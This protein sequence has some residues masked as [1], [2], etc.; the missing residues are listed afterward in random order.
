[1]ATFEHLEGDPVA[2]DG[3]VGDLE[4]SVTAIDEAIELLYSTESSL[5]GDAASELYARSLDAGIALDAARDRYAGTASALRTYVVEMRAAHEAA[6][7]VLDA[8]AA[9]VTEQRDA[10]DAAWY[11]SN[12]LT[13]AINEAAPAGRIEALREEDYEARRRVARAEESLTDLSATWQAAKDRQDR[14]AEAAANAI[15]DAMDATND[16]FWDGVGDFFSSIGEGL[17]AAWNWTVE[18]LKGIGEFLLQFAGLALAF[19]VI[20]GLLLLLPGVGVGLALV[21]GG[22][23]FVGIAGFLVSASLKADGRGD[24]ELI[25]S[26]TQTRSADPEATGD[27]APVTGY[28]DLIGTE[29]GEVDRLTGQWAEYREDG[30]VVW[31]DREELAAAV[32]VV[33]LR[34]EDTGE[35]IG[36]R[37]QLPST[38]DWGT[39]S[40]AINDLGA[41]VLHALV[42]GANTQIERAAFDAMR[43]AGVFDS[44]APIMLTGWSQGGMTAGE[45]AIDDRLAGREISVVTA[46]SPVDCF[47]NE[48]AERGIQVT[49][50]TQVD[51][52][53]GLEGLRLTPA[54]ALAQNPDFE[55]HFQWSVDHSSDGYGLMA[56]NISPTL[57]RGDDRFFAD[58]GEGIVE[59]VH[60]YEY[61]RPPED[62]S[63]ILA[64]GPST[65]GEYAG[66]T[67]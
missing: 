58:F 60:T 41:D 2:L 36:W 46:G 10:A 13:I 50:F 21:L 25:D 66:A 37:V 3:E 64:P 12:A 1:M 16:G 43:R 9:A 29:L 5:T 30:S 14:A 51:G 61:R 15:R 44:N 40:G 55:Q 39:D 35:I 63:V 62:S 8:G 67:A 56:G 34:D 7:A 38:Q 32:R 22:L 31:H 18:L 26:Q 6:D 33:A 24:P 11:A 47:R 57:R 52:V 54:D 23:L 4:A 59:D 42:P 49:S 20:V 65:Q 27:R 45:V 17:A 28:G 53:S 19:L 48:F